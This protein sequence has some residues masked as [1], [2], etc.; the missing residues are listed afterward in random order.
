[1]LS[2]ASVYDPSTGGEGGALGHLY[3]LLAI[4]VFLG[5]NGH[6]ALLRGLRT[7]FETVPSMTAATGQAIVPMLIGLLQSATVVAIQL[8]APIFV[9]MLI[10]DLALGMVARTIPQ[11]GVLTVGVTL[12][13]V[14]G[15]IV[16]IAGLAITAG[17]FQ[18]VSMNW[19]FVPR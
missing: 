12:R 10:V 3:K 19:I 7:S 8:A 2:L 15:L 18:I 4:V 14:T 11:L 16:L 13:S 9:T 6:H 5:A 17:V 1:G